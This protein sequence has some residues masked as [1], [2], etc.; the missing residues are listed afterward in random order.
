MV[1]SIVNSNDNWKKLCT[2]VVSRKKF[3]WKTTLSCSQKSLIEEY[4]THIWS[5]VMIAYWLKLGTSTFYNWMNNGRIYF[6]LTNLPHLNALQR[7][8]NETN[9]IPLGS[10][11]PLKID[12]IKLITAKNFIIGKLI[13]FFLDVV[14][15]KPIWLPWL[16][17]RFGCCGAF[18]F[19]T[20]RRT[21]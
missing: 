10:N 6:F 11:S 20:E 3:G 16:N 14:K 1:D 19:L 2:M 5:P 4:M 13:P 18:K 9:G 17:G 12:R 15:T 7:R 8:K 21:P